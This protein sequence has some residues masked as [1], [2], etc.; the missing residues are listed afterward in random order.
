MKYSQ[1]KLYNT[2]N[3][4]LSTQDG[5]HTCFQTETLAVKSEKVWESLQFE[6]EI[7]CFW[8][9]CFPYIFAYFLKSIITPCVHLKWTGSGKCTHLKMGPGRHASEPSRRGPCVCWGGGGSVD[10]GR[11]GM[12]CG[13]PPSNLPLPIRLRRRRSARLFTAT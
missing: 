11:E 4:Q 13:L 7:Y 10:S 1:C 3:L 5:G 2:I 12:G 9:H 6:D 8:F